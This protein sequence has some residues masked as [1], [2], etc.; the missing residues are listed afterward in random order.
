MSRMSIRLLL[1][2]ILAMLGSSLPSLAQTPAEPK[3]P[4][5]VALAADAPPAGD[6]PGA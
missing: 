4:A 1:L 6:A 5:A 3:P 2:C